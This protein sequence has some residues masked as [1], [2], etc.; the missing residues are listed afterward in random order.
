MHCVQ[1]LQNSLSEMVGIAGEEIRGFSSDSYNKFY[2]M[3]E[4][5]LKYNGRFANTQGD[6]VLLC[7]MSL[8]IVLSS[9]LSG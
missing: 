1:N 2:Y 7:L 6:F 9:M 5:N 3:K 8:T 4:F